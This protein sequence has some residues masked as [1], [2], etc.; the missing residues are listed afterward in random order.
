M[1]NR[2]LSGS[3]SLAA[4]G[5]ALRYKRNFRRQH[6][7]YFDPDGLLVFCGPQGSGKT[8]SAVQYCK[9]ILSAYPACKFVT[10]VEIQGLPETTE[11]IEYNGLDTLMGVSNGY[12]GVLYLIDELHL[13]FNSLESKSMVVIL[14]SRVLPVIH[15]ILRYRYLRLVVLHRL[16]IDFTMIRHDLLVRRIL[17]SGLQSRCVP[18]MMTPLLQLW[19]RSLCLDCLRL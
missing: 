6:P 16:G 8:L 15:L 14:I 13:E 4:G 18:V 17:M 1:K 7:E 9:H 2:F 5:Q 11:V 12:A 10:N 19:P 3:L